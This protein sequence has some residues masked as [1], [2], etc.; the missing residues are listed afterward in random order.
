MGCCCLLEPNRSAISQ[1]ISL[2]SV[3]DERDRDVAS[4]DVAAYSGRWSAI[5]V[6]YGDTSDSDRQ[7]SLKINAG[8]E[9]RDS[10]YHFSISGGRGNTSEI[11][12]VGPRWH[13][14]QP[15]AY[16]AGPEGDWVNHHAIGIHLSS[17]D[18]SQKPLRALV[19]LV[20]QLQSQFQ[21]P[22]DRVI[23][24]EDHETESRSGRWFPTAWFRQQ[25]LTFSTP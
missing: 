4:E 7:V 10:R 25:L 16:W 14:Q 20:Q 2:S 8:A 24:Q 12:E 6:Q 23:L 21:I 3:N 15:G 13:H 22:A 5:V 1:E 17:L 18:G 11:V 19:T 9:S